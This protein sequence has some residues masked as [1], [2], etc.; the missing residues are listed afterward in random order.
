MGGRCLEKLPH[1][2]GTNSGLQVFAREEDDTV[3]GYCFSCGS[4]VR[5]PYG[6]EKKAGEIP[7]PKE[8]T[9]E[10]IAAEIAEVSGYPTVELP[11]R[12]LRKET[13]EYFGVKIALSEK[14]GKTPLERYYPAKL[15]GKITGYK[16]KT[17]I[18]K[19]MWAIG[20]L[21]GVDFFGWDQAIA[22][23][24]KKLIVTTGE[25]DAVALRRAIEM[26]TPHEYKDTMPAVVSCVHGDGSAK[27]DFIRMK[28]K[29]N[30][31]FKEVILAFDMD[32]S[33]QEAASE[34]SKIMPYVTVAALPAKDANE[35][36]KE[37]KSK[38]LY[39]ACVF[40][41]TRKLNTSIIFGEDVHAAA[42]EPAKWGELSWPWQTLQ[43]LTR[44]IRYGETYFIG[45]GVKMGKSELLNAIAAHFIMK[46]NQKVFLAKPEESINKT[47]KLLAGKLVGR[48]FHDPKR[49]FDYKAYDEAG[50]ILK[51][52]LGMLDLYQHMSWEA[53]KAHIIEA[54]DWGAKVVM[55]DP[56][57]NLTN[58]MDSG[59]ANV[60]LQEIAQDLSAMAKDLNIAIFIFCHLKAPEGNLSKD[61]REKK[62]KQGE[63]MSL[64]NCPHELGGDILSAQFAGSRAMMRSCNYMIGLEGNKDDTLPDHLRVRRKLRIL[65]DR[66][67]GE[68][69]GP[70]L[71][72]DR[73]TTFY[74]EV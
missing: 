44:G 22:S 71:T 30:M 60:K 39:N 46:N 15:D 2:C 27:A 47:Y 67:F 23:G 55:I 28:P 70:L 36:V 5:H 61:V 16:V 24:S 45:A 69:G 57:T 37:G 17:V 48:V 64:G 10:E 35:A 32:E 18:G 9:P 43:E 14:D 58:G 40:N 26:H 6:E 4:P 31:Y 68:T 1:S 29:I 49:E 51:G 21:K 65:E 20:S 12:K 63:Y 59:D 41:S 50:E 66:E 56:I 8:K 54:V 38:A 19:K 11:S 73:E 13:L 7:K 33:G 53:L 34:V 25:D 42:R 72:F 74:R 52:Q 62:Y 3:D